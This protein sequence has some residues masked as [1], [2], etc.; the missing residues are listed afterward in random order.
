MHEC[1][2]R[3]QEQLKLPKEEMTNQVKAL[4]DEFT[5]EEVSAKIAEIITPPNI[6]PKVEVIYQTIED[7]RASCPKNNGD[8]YFSGEYPTPGGNRVVNKSFIYYM[9]GRNERAY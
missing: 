4:Y 8:W 2:E 6:K 1:Y 9:E 3:C 7:L 5:Y